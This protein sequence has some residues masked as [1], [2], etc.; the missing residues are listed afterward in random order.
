[1]YIYTYID[2]RSLVAYLMKNTCG[3]EWL[4][5]Y[6]HYICNILYIC[7]YIRHEI[8]LTNYEL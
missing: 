3:Q 6:T 4:V 8:K 7:I 5:V 1:M 2:T